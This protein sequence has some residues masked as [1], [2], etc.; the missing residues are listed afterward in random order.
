MKKDGLILLG[1]ATLLC[2]AACSRDRCVVVLLPKPD[3]TAG[4]LIVSN[5]EGSQLLQKPNLATGIQSSESAPKAPEYMD[6]QKI[7][8]LFG[9]ALKGL[10]PP[11]IHFILYFKTDTTELTDESRKILTG[12]L[13]AIADHES[14]DVSVIG[15]TDR[16][17]TRD[18]NFHLALDRALLV[19]KILLALGINP[20][21]IEVTSHGEDNPLIPT[22]DEVPEPRNRR[23]EVV[24][25]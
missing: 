25:R 14:T 11:P 1:L 3:G 16:V 8:K 20:K 13:P 2:L 6:T 12:I 9:E 17:G 18:Y 5:R 21:F 24:V 7:Q 4:S 22:A 23:V 10:P 19:Q 15:H